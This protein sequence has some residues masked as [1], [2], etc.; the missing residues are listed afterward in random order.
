[1]LAEI[2]LLRKKLRSVHRPTIRIS[3]DNPEIRPIRAYPVL[4]DPYA[5]VLGEG[6]SYRY[7]GDYADQGYGAVFFATPPTLVADFLGAYLVDAKVSDF[8][9]RPWNSF[10][11]VHCRGVSDRDAAEHLKT[12]PWNPN[13]L[14]AGLGSHGDVAKY[15]WALIT[16]ELRCDDDDDDDDDCRIKAFYAACSQKDP[17]RVLHTQ[18]SLEDVFGGALEALSSVCIDAFEHDV[19]VPDL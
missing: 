2:A 16:N 19:P 12:R 11:W 3:D 18:V 14:R 4:L 7:E 17:Y 13:D 9:T 6:F 8:E 15:E 5:Q 10:H 1:L